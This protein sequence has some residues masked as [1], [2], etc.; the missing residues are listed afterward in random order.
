MDTPSFAMDESYKHLREQDLSILLV[1][2]PIALG[3]DLQVSR[4]EDHP[5]LSQSLK[6]MD[7]VSDQLSE[8]NRNDLMLLLTLLSLPVTRIALGLWR[9]WKEATRDEL[10]GFLGRWEKSIMSF[11]RFG[12]Q[13]LMQLME[14]AFYGVPGNAAAIGYPGIPPS[15]GP[16]LRRFQSERT[17]R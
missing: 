8:R 9:P 4:P 15:I 7:H 17:T 6:A 10:V 13:S 1:L 3:I 16:F 12:Y 11:R 2:L 14:Y 5:L